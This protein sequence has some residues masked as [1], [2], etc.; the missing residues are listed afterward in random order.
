MSRLTRS[1]TKPIRQRTSWCETWQREDH[2]LIRCWERGREM[3]RERPD[4]AVRASRGELPIL[5]WRGGIDGELKIKSK[6][7]VMQYLA[8]WQGLRGDDLDVPL[9]GE[10]QVV[11]SRTGIKVTFTR[12]TSKFGHG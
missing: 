3:Q 2:G 7:G 6:Y 12:D 5:P 9:D 8:M 1:I 4:L 11:C 10:E